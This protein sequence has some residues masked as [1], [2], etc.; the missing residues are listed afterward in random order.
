MISRKN[1]LNLKARQQIYDFIFKN[2][3]VH[4][5]EISRRMYVPKTTLKH[6]IKYLKKQEL[7]T[8]K[9][10]GKYKR[11]Y[12]SKKIGEKDKKL[13]NLLRQ[14]TPFQIL[15]YML[16]CVVCSQTDL[17]KELDKHP[18]TIAHHLK[19]LMDM[20][21]IQ[22]S[23]M[24]DGLMYRITNE[25]FIKRSPVGSEK[26]YGWTDQETVETVYDLIITHKKSLANEKIIDDY[27]CWMEKVTEGGSP[28]RAVDTNDA[29]DAILEV[30]YEI[31]PHP[32]HV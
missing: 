25:K 2:P 7:I 30:A 31:C 19:K 22:L 1:I 9:T 27:V 17:S 29:I 21:I 3:G 26:I 6:H 11:I 24:E 32:Y 28:N 13:L 10:E 20:N 15:L 4:I 23:P 8:V 18:A 14:E 5:R 12:A 16:F